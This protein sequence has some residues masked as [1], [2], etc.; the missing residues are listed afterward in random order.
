MAAYR[1]VYDSVTCRL[2]AKN[3]DQLRN[4]T[5]GNR[6]RATF[7]F[8]S[9]AVCVS[10]APTRGA[11]AGA[12]TATSGSLAAPMSRASRRSSSARGASSADD[13]WYRADHAAISSPGTVPTRSSPA[14]AVTAAS[15]TPSPD[16]PSPLPTHH[17]SLVQCL[18]QPSLWG[19]RGNSAPSPKK[20]YNSPSKTAATLC[21]LNLYSAHM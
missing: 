15:A 16:R 9:F 12:R 19:R 1:R 5:L 8:F 14:A 4:R 18:F 17:P 11:P 21:A 6:V 3:R 10:C 20:T 2:T 13:R 7:T